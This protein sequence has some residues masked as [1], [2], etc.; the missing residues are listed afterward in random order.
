METELLMLIA[1]GPLLVAGLYRLLGVVGSPRT[2]RGRT[3][4]V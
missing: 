2:P 3:G 1:A 4:F